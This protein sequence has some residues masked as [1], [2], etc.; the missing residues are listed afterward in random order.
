MRL[1]CHYI[2]RNNR[3]ERR[4]LLNRLENI[5][6]NIDLE[7]GYER[8]TK[9]EKKVINLYY[10]EGYKDEEIAAFYGIT[11]QVINRLRRKGINKLKIF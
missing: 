10:L 7:K 1:F 11:Q 6:I 3:G 9:R 8:L 2:P 4:I 5:L